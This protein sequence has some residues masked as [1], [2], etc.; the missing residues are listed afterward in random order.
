[1]PKATLEFTLPEEAAEHRDAIQGGTW[2]GVVGEFD[3]QLRAWQR[4][5]A[6]LPPT[7]TDPMATVDAIRELLWKSLAEYNLN[8]N[9]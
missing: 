8:L 5:K 1:M 7:F 4:G 9:D 2:R 3:N 6:D